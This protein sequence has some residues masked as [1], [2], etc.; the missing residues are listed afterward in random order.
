[1]FAFCLPDGRTLLTAH[2]FVL[3]DGNA[4][5][6]NEY[7]NGSL[8]ASGDP[9]AACCSTIPQLQNPDVNVDGVT[10]DAAVVVAEQQ[11]VEGA[12]KGSGVIHVQVQDTAAVEAL[13][14][15]RSAMRREEEETAGGKAEADGEAAALLG[16]LPPPP[17]ST[18]LTVDNMNMIS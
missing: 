17:T 12:A 7:W 5:P 13:M 14:L 16:L 6:G 10:G 1:V 11:L 15:A 2:L 4:F 3:Q 9:A 8:S 18:V